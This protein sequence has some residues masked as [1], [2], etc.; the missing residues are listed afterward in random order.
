MRIDSII[1]YFL[2]K[3]DKFYKLFEDVS[4]LLIDATRLLAQF[5]SSDGTIAPLLAKQIKSLE[6][7]ADALTHTIFGEVNSTFVTPFDREDIHELASKLD[8]I[9][10]YIDGSASRFVLY[11]VD[12]KDECITHL[13][14]ILGKSVE[15]VS[16]G[17]AQLKNFGKS[18][19]IQIILK[20]INSYENEADDVFARGVANLFE[21]EKDVI[22]LIKLKEIYVGLETATDRCEDVANVLEAIL[23]KHT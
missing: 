23:I 15:S 16:K 9:M 18:D 3:H 7:Q 17:I 5:P 2:P 21:N 19:D 22:R 10:D 13:I 14:K 12:A 8:D 11:K 20:D 6:H 1:H 4:H